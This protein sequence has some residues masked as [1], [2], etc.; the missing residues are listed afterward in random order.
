MLQSAGYREAVAD[1]NNPKSDVFVNGFRRFMRR[2]NAE[3]A[4]ARRTALGLAVVGSLI[5]GGVGYLVGLFVG[6]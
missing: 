4:A 2:R 1:M 5:A 6:A 3:L